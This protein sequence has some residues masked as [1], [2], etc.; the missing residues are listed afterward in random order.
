MYLCKS[1]GGT[2]Q[3]SE[4]IS[5]RKG[6]VLYICSGC[7]EKWQGK[8][9]YGYMHLYQVKKPFYSGDRKTGISA[10]LYRWQKERLAKIG[11]T[12]QQILDEGIGKNE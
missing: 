12:P 5:D 4:Y 8:V 11:K 2:L 10:R 6:E 9:S 3:E 1:C 7:G